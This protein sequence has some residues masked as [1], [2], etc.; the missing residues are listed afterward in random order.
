MKILKSIHSLNPAGGGVA[1]AVDVLSR[2]QQSL[3]HEVTVACLDDPAS[4]WLAGLPYAVQ[5]FAPPCLRGYGWCPAFSRWLR[6]N[7][8]RFDIATVEGLWQFHGPA[9][10]AAALAANIPYVVYPHG[11]LDPWF[12]RTYP[13]KH[14]KKILYWHL[15]EHRVLRDARAV[16][17][18][19]DEELRLAE[20][21]FRPWSARSV[22]A[23]LGVAAPSGDTAV[24][25]RQWYERHP[26]L[27]N[28]KSLL[29]LGRIDLKK[30]VDLLLEAYAATYSASARAALTSPALVLAGP[31]SDPAFAAH[32][33][34]LAQKLGL[35]EGV[36][37]FW[38]GLLAGDWKWAALEAADALVLPSHQE[39]F[40]YVIAEALAVGT[41][42]LLSK[43]VNIW[44][45]IT[46]SGAGL[47]DEDDAAGTQ[48][49]LAA[50]A[51]WTPDLRRQFS[52]AAR[53]CFSANFQLE[54]AARYQLAVLAGPAAPPSPA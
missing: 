34:A 14:C 44:R 29:F 38:T 8:R 22:V 30:G 6:E 28:R 51:L 37:I 5:A 9:T 39:N 33:R 54:A 3:G 48:R 32:C 23:P 12:R 13:V 16:I 27:A 50:H 36:D 7:L 19:A 1:T 11:M 35:R 20:G 52:A 46:D 24:R 47:A 40:G 18:T 45:T 21:E 41:P 4:P 2:T 25:A 31:E 15:I 43:R 17:F 26:A 53:A 49:L 10:R 42:V